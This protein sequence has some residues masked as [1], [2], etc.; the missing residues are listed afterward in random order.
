MPIGRNDPCPCGSGRKF[1]KCH[2]AATS[3]APASPEAARARTLKVA[4]VELGERLVRFARMRHGPDW[5]QEV[6]DSEPLFVELGTPADAEMPIFIPWLLFFRR[7]ADDATIADEWRREQVMRPSSDAR[8]LQD[9]YAEAWMSVWEVAEVVRGVGSRMKDLLTGEERFVH[10]VRSAETLERFDSMLAIIVTCDGISFFGGG[11]AQPLPPQY[12]EQVVRAGR[13]LCRVRTRPAPPSRLRDPEV[14]LALL[15]TWRGMVEAMMNRPA[16]TLQ[17]TDGDPFVLTRDDFGLLGPRADVAR[18]LAT[19]P[20]VQERE[21]EGDETVFTMTRPGNTVHRSWDNTVVGRI[22]LANSRLTVETNSARRADTLRSTIEARLKGLVR[23][24]LRKEENT[25]QL[26]E[27]ARE[28]RP[29]RASRPGTAVPAETEVAVRQFREQH[30]REWL[31]DSIPALGGL[32][33]REA[34]R[35]AR[36]RP[37]LEVLL[38]EM[39]RSEARLPERERIDLGWVREALEV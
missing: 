5:L 1:K 14:Q 21:E 13:R 2:G 19:I 32:T 35:S 20:G 27:A 18:A 37:K 29:A 12:A 25:A 4:D 22:A 8:L 7:G 24:R 26:M 16:P 17:N 36:A 10:D 38:K 15:A 6:L 31:D 9:A 39:E 11:H 23:F 33:P 30:L 34:A 28:S 3:D